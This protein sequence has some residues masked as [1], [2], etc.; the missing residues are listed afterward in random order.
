MD[1][2]TSLSPA[3]PPR[4]GWEESFRLMAERGDDR[5]LDPDVPICLDEEEWEW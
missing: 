5:L 4:E 3:R 1:N 2:Q